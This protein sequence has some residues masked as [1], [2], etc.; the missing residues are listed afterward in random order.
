MTPWVGRLI[1]A[2]AVVMLLLAT[3]LTSGGVVQA[4]AFDPASVLARPW[5]IL[6]YMFVHGGVLHLAANM[7]ALYVFGTP[8]EN[9]LGGRPFL[10]YYLGCG[11]GAALASLAMAALH[12]N[13]APVVGASGAVLGIAV[14]FAM[15]WPDAEILI[16]PIPVPIRARVLVFLYAFG[17]LAMALFGTQDGIAHPAHVGGLL[18]GWIF[19]KLRDRA[20]R[21]PQPRARRLE[22]V[23]MAQSVVRDAAPINQRPARSQPAQNDDPMTAEV[24]RVLDKISARGIDSLTSDERRFL[25]EMSKRKRDL[26]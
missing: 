18:F 1:A 14:A 26:N 13:P 8:V 12:Y 5:T 9:R 3:V 16:F 21:A 10:L 11:I 24:D 2:N 25:E 22:P 17:Q 15:L 23:V 4:L 19:F 7:L 20:P 6:T